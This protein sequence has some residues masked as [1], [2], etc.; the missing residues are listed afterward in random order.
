[1]YINYVLCY[2]HSVKLSLALKLVVFPDKSM[3]GR[4][5]CLSF[6]LPSS[7]KHKLNLYFLMIP[8]RVPGG[9][10]DIRRFR[11]DVA[12]AVRFLGLV[13]AGKEGKSQTTNSDANILCA[14]LRLAS[15]TVNRKRYALVLDILLTLA[16]LYY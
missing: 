3:L 1:M 16:L 9:F 13:G 10:Q 12:T 4:Q 6:P 5:S 11:D 14:V 8:F 2:L 7:V 15:V